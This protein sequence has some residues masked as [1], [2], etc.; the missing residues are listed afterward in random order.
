MYI[1][2]VALED[3]VWHHEHS[4]EPGRAARPS[5]VE[6]WRKIATV[7]DPAWTRRYHAADP[8]ARAFGGRAV[9]ELEGGTT[10][11]DELAVADAHPL[12]AKPFD[13]AAYVEKFRTLA[14]GVV[15]DTEQHRFLDAA[16]HL[17]ELSPG[18]LRVLGFVASDD[19]GSHPGAPRG[20][21]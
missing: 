6:L 14:A 9:V 2:A 5:T 3:G 18:E 11:E 17:A 15:D 10:I 20:I 8:A 12:G 1:L 13:R 19:V 7:E 21:L 16:A 4:Y